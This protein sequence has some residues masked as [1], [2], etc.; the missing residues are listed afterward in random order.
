MIAHGVVCSSWL[1]W[2]SW[3][4]EF[5]VSVV[6]LILSDVIYTKNFWINVHI[7]NKWDF[8]VDFSYIPFFV[9]IC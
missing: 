8:A 2:G 9:N 1:G 4:L 7:C 5:A 3:E 6:T